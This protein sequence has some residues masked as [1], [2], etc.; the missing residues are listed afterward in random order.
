M[1]GSL[2][3][4]Q[5]WHMSRGIVFSEAKEVVYPTLPLAAFHSSA[6]TAEH[7]EGDAP[8]CNPLGS[9]DAERGPSESPAVNAPEPSGSDVQRGSGRGTVS[10]EAA[11]E[12]SD[13]PPNAGEG[14]PVHPPV[15]SLDFKIP[16]E[17]FQEARRAE[18]GTPESFW[19]YSLYRGPGEGGALDAKVKVHYCKSKHT[20][21]RVL[22]NYFMD[23]KV[24]GFD[25]EWW[26][27]ATR[28][29]GARYNTSLIQIASQSRIALFHLALYPKN[30]SLVAPSLKKILEDPGVTK[31]GVCIKGDCTR[32]R[33]FLQVNPRG[34]FELSH[35]YK[36]VKHS[37]TGNFHHVNRRVVSLATQT[38]EYLRLPLFKGSDVRSSDWSQ[39][40]QMSQIICEFMRACLVLGPSFQAFLPRVV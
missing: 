22:Q 9:S 10:S 7:N 27:N 28:H 2:P 34:I 38:N 16:E 15:T 8:P 37:S 36:L 35:L 24:I 18:P 14:R 1:A 31:V 30:D 33:N 12:D 5:L 17:I 40:L 11:G 21:E 26:P 6:A 23:E 32:V 20:T 39:Q 3:R 29:Q 13:G 4:V 25:L 19:S